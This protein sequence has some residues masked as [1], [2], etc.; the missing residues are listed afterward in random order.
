[1]VPA[2]FRAAT[3]RSTYAGQEKGAA[4]PCFLN[5]GAAVRGFNI[6]QKKNRLRQSAVAGMVVASPEALYSAVNRAVSN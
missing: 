2:H 3:D 6:R 4:L 5:I 1:M